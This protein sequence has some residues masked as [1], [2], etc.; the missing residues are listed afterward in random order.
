[1]QRLVLVLALL[2]P[3]S[4]AAQPSRYDE[5]VAIER[6]GDMRAAVKAYVS[7]ARG[8]DARAARRLSDIYAK[9]AD[10]IPRDYAES[11][12]WDNAAR[13]LGERMQGD[14]P[15]RKRGY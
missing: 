1:M 14:F 5:A 11:Q 8:G 10:G 3:V 12:K 9:G 2:L 7:A 15:D 4:T 13:T 6:S